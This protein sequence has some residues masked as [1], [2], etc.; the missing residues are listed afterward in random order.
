MLATT[1]PI[2]VVCFLTRLEAGLEGVPFVGSGHLTSRASG[3]YLDGAG[4]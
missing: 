3:C 1:V 2:V 4:G